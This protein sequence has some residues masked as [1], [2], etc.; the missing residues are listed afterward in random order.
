MRKPYARQSR[1]RQLLLLFYTSLVR[2]PLFH[3]PEFSLSKCKLIAA[4]L[5]LLTFLVTLCSCRR[6][7]N[8]GVATCGV[9]IGVLTAI[10]TTAVAVVCCRFVSQRAH[11]S[12]S[13]LQVDIV[14][15][16]I[17]RQ[18]L[19][20]QAQTKDAVTANYGNGPWMM[21]A[22]A[23]AAWIVVI[24]T[25]CDCCSARKRFWSPHISS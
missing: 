19:A 15:I 11:F 16:V 17:A 9:L 1:L 18:K 3:F 22:A 12:S 20:E 14:F 24:G 23:V 13:L 25:C 6:N 5:A 21:V 4:A 2:S 8:K 10:L 7:A